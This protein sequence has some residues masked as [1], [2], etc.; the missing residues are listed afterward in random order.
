MYTAL[1]LLPPPCP[2]PLTLSISSSSSSSSLMYYSTACSFSCSFFSSSFFSIS[3]SL[4]CFFICLSFSLPFYLSSPSPIF[5][6]LL[7]IKQKQL[8]S[9]LLNSNLWYM[10]MFFA[11]Y[12]NVVL[13]FSSVPLTTTPKAPPDRTANT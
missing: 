5:V 13:V 10:N 2:P 9:T 4:F 1:F 11:V 8:I 3:F 6:P 12:L 7:G